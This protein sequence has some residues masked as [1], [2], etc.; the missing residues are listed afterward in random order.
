MQ[1][2]TTRASSN[3]KKSPLQD[4]A[5]HFAVRRLMRYGSITK[6]DIMDIVGCSPGTANCALALIRKN[7]GFV[8]QN[9]QRLVLKPG[10]FIETHLEWMAIASDQQ[11]NQAIEDGGHTELTGLKPRELPIRIKAWSSGRSLSPGLMSA[12]AKC[13]VHQHQF[14]KLDHRASLA[15]RYVGMKKGETARWRIIVP[16]GLDRVL[17]QWR[18]IAQDLG[19]KDYPLR[20]YVIPRI[21]EHKVVTEPLPKDFSLRPFDDSQSMMRISFNVELT[22]DQEMVIR[23]EMKIDATATTIQVD[24]RTGLDFLRR[25]GAIPTSED[26]VWPII[27]SL[28]NNKCS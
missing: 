26:A 14:R 27:A 25:F 23:N 18:L 10:A 22:R 24:K 2:K 1:D 15:I 19:A 28:D 7:K 9:G 4:R 13:L 17:D 8:E 16:L 20:T 11:L 12:I 5:Y 21:I 3:A 6:A